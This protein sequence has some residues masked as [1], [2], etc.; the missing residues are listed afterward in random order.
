MVELH[1]RAAPRPTRS[2]CTMGPTDLRYELH[3]RRGH[4]PFPPAHASRDI[5][6]VLPLRCSSLAHPIPLQ[7]LLADASNSH[8]RPR[9]KKALEVQVGNRERP[10]RY[11]SLGLRASTIPG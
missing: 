9:M 6:N 1:L 11:R 5:E 7:A 4:P 3:P 10:A 2:G 8:V